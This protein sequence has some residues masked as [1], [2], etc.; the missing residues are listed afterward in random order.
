MKSSLLIKVLS[1][2]L[3]FLGALM[4]LMAQSAYWTNST[5]FNQKKFTEITVNAVS[6]ES[7]RD[8]IASTIVNK[9]LG[10]YPI[11]NQL[12]GDRVQS[13]ISGLLGTDLST[14][15]IESLTSKS[16]AYITTKDRSDISINLTPIKSTISGLMLFANNQQTSTEL[17]D[18]QSKIPE[19]I[20]LVKSDDF[21]NISGLVNLMLW[22]HP[23][24]WAAC[25]I[26]FGLYIYIG[27]KQFAR[28]I[29]TVC[30]TII[31]V[32]LIGLMV[33]PFILPPLTAAVQ[34][35]SLRPVI[36]N[37]ASGF[38]SPFNSQMYTML[39]VT[40]V[41]LIIFSQRT[42]ILQLVTIIG[43]KIRRISVK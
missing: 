28:R 38:L 2:L 19:Q 20:V 32:A 3:L 26:L 29:Y 40:I 9:S 1:P 21:P 5:I 22:L 13:F 24:F 7:S 12:V 18:A 6:T 10:E 16:Y 14:K 4:L 17:S 15:L 8:A 35:I 23:V 34:E 39:W 30:A 31:A 11:I 36:E 33:G 25:I 27:K 37:I 41:F 42:H 43:N